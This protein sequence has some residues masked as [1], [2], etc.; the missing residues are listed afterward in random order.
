MLKIPR[1]TLLFHARMLASLG[2][3]P[4]QLDVSQVLQT[5]Q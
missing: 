3:N 2:K 5:V 4:A 1:S